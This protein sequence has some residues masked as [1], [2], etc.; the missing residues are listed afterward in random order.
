MIS[1]LTSWGKTLWYKLV[2]DYVQNSLESF[3][4]CWNHAFS[5]TFKKK[6]LC[7][8][9]SLKSLLQSNVSNTLSIGPMIHTLQAGEWLSSKKK[10]PFM[11]FLFVD[12]C[13]YFIYFLVTDS[14]HWNQILSYVFFEDWKRKAYRDF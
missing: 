11:K 6:C 10:K 7:R 2:S 5:F 14:N 3:C 8:F 12:F 13:Y 4:H 1:V 9:L